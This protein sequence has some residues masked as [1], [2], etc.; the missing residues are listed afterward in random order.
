MTGNF[1]EDVWA[2][3]EEEVYPNLFGALGPGIFS[4]G[5]DVFTSVFKQSADPRW[6]HI[7]V[8]ESPPSS[9]HEDWVYVTSGLSNPWEDDSPPNE[10][11]GPSWLGL[12]FVFRAT[13]SGPWAIQAVQ[14]VA[15]F[16]ILLAHGRYEG[17]ERLGFGDRIPLRGPIIPDSESQISHLLVAPPTG[18]PRGFSL[19]SGTVD[20]VQLIGISEPEAKFARENGTQALLSLLE[21]RG[22]CR[23]T[24]PMRGSLL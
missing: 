15:A 9:A 8:F 5:I 24:D 14:R 12:E 6:M 22:A 21:S 16:E 11:S 1:L 19:P 10:A 13:T 17:R 4:I 20:F 2:K 3:R 7:G 23:T 18:M